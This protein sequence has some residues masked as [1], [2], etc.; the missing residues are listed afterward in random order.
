MT[1]EDL[2]AALDALEEVMSY[3][4]GMPEEDWVEFCNRTLPLM[5]AHGRFTGT[6]GWF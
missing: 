2:E 3:D 1:D 6:V 4:K 5:Q